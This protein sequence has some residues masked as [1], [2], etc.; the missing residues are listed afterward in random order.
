[1]IPFEK[2]FLGLAVDKRNRKIVH[3]LFGETRIVVQMVIQSSRR[4][5]WGS[6]V[7]THMWVQLYMK[8]NFSYVKKPK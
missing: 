3:P 4:M 6:V 2:L 8:K 7:S 1:M 5:V